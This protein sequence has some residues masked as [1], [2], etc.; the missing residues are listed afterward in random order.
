MVSRKG[1]DLARRR[2]AMAVSDEGLRALFAS[3]QV[4][5]RRMGAAAAKATRT[6]LE[7]HPELQGNERVDALLN[8]WMELPTKDAAYIAAYERDEGVTI[9]SYEVNADANGK[10]A[11]EF[12]SQ[13]GPPPPQPAAG[14]PAGRE[15]A[16]LSGMRRGF[17][18]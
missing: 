2:A 4:P 1:E 15:A 11:R 10:D 3:E 7:K 12:E 8:K 17:L 18:K 16:F 9:T 5:R 13:I 14:R 6:F